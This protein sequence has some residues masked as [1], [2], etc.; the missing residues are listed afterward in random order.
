MRRGHKIIEEVVEIH[1]VRRESDCFFRCCCCYC[2]FI[3]E[4]E[5]R[6]REEKL[7]VDLAATYLRGEEEEVSCFS[8]L[9]ILCRRS[10]W[11]RRKRRKVD[12]STV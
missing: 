11:E 9:R 5:K 4:E 6:G 12:E 10:S 1:D 2:S 3:C 8:T 7:D